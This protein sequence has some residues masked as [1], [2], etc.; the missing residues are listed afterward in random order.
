MRL[1][2]MKFSITKFR[3]MTFYRLTLIRMTP[4]MGLGRMTSISNK[5]S[6]KLSL[7]ELSSMSFSRVTF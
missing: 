4:N 5:L 2:R 1:G 6:K 3:R 7:M